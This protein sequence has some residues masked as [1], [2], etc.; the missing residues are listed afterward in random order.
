MCVITFF[1]GGWA[2]FYVIKSFGVNLE[3]WDKII[4]CVNWEGGV[5]FCTFFSFLIIF[6]GFQ[7]SFMSL[8]ELGMCSFKRFLLFAVE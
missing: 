2:G 3:M 8:L 7:V 1:I 6:F 5:E 4:V